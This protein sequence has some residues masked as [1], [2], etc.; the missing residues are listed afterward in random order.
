MLPSDRTDL[1]QFSNYIA[2]FNWVRLSLAE[3]C[4]VRN[5]HHAMMSLPASSCIC[6]QGLTCLSSA[7]A[8]LPQNPDSCTV[9]PELSTFKN[10]TQAARGAHW[11]PLAHY[12]TCLLR[13]L[14]AAPQCSND[15]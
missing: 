4:T 13:Q 2:V 8:S 10:V 5:K 7:A 11:Q 12:C 15:A 14:V 1:A 9:P 3:P 6:T